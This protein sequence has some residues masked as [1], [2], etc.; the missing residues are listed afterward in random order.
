MSSKKRRLRQFSNREL[1]LDRSPLNRISAGRPVSS[2]FTL[3]TN[4]PSH[5]PS[6]LCPSVLALQKVSLLI[7]PTETLASIVAADLA[8]KVSVGGPLF[9]STAPI[10]AAGA[11]IVADQPIICERIMPQLESVQTDLSLVHF[12]PYSKGGPI[13]PACWIGIRQAISAN[14]NVRLIIGLVPAGSH[15]LVNILTQLQAI[16]L[17]SSV[18]VLPIVTYSFATPGSKRKLVSQ[19]SALPIV[20]ALGDMSRGSANEP[21][22]L[23]W[24]KTIIG[25]DLPA[26]PFAVGSTTTDSGQAVASLIWSEAL[27][28]VEMVPPARGLRHRVRQLDQAKEVLRGYL[29]EPK[30]SGDCH[31]HASAAGISPSTLSRAAVALGVCKKHGVWQLPVSQSSPTNQP[32]PEECGGVGGGQG[33]DDP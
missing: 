23:R 1:F 6:Y 10:N 32:P 2:S 22:V 13:G 8:H 3:A 11:I 16:A 24:E 7:A 5:P 9:G 12:V 18:A 19:L 21:W 25:N 4:T 27:G 30:S 26:L 31:E 28:V 33:C 20:D 17:V 29:S 14:R 15:G